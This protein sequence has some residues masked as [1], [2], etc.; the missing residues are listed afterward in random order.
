MLDMMDLAGMMEG[1]EVG[2]PLCLQKN[3]LD[4]WILFVGA[5]CALMLCAGDA[6]H[7]CLGWRALRSAL[8]TP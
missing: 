8:V 5:S 1:Y 6:R 2:F 4:S 7:D 3:V